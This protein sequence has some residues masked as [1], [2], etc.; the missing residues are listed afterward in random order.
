[1]TDAARELIRWSCTWD[2]SKY[3]EGAVAW[4]TERLHRAP[5]E[6]DFSAAGIA[7]YAEAVIPENLVTTAGWGR[8]LSLF[9]G[10]GG[11][12][13]DNTHTR[14]GVGN[15]AG[16]AA[17]GDVD[18]SAAAGSTNRWFQVM[19]ATFPT[20]AGAALTFKATLGASDGN[21]AWT[22]FGLDISTAAAVSGNTVGP[23]LI[24]HKTGIA[25]GTKI[26]GQSW[27]GTAVI[28]FT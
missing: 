4:L 18:L 3:D 24:N 25:Q 9:I 21:F 12:A 19:D 1:M 8:I 23:L 11:Q 28:T 26:A 22:E 16:T 7:P 17:A 6:A 13:A 5:T 15:G 20:A 2:V 10:G 14:L 27:T